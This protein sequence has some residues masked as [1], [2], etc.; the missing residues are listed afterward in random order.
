L[1]LRRPPL[2]AFISFTARTEEA[3]SSMSRSSASLMR[4][5]NGRA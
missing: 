1:N 3:P 4:R 5:V 2:A